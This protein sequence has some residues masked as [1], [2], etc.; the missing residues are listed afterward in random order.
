MAKLIFTYKNFITEYMN[1]EEVEPL[2]EDA[3]IILENKDN[4]TN[5]ENFNERDLRYLMSYH[6]LS[7]MILQ[8]P[9]CRKLSNL[10]YNHEDDSITVFENAKGTYICSCNEVSVAKRYRTRTL[11]VRSAF[12]NFD[13]SQG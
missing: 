1:K 5:I 4:D 10:E 3:I 2:P 9:K 8:C 13:I 12:R 7:K 11:E 6:K